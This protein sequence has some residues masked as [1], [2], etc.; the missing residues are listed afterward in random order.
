[1]N[2]TIIINITV[3][4]IILLLLPPEHHPYYS[5]VSFYPHPTLFGVSC[6]DN[7]VKANSRYSLVH[8]LSAPSSK[9]GP[10]VTVI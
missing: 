1:M 3:I 5:A 4:I 9:S 7:S 8:I 2:I 10:N 6:R